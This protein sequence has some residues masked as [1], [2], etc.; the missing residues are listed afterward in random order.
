MISR[1][2]L[3][4]WVGFT[5]GIAVQAK[6]WPVF[7]GNPQ[8]TGTTTAHL[9]DQLTER[10]TFTCKNG[11]EGAPAIVGDTV[12]LASLGEH[13]YALELA[14]GR[15]K[16]RIRLAPMKAAPAVANGRVF[17]GDIDGKFYCVDA[18]TGKKLWMFETGGEITSGA[19]FHGDRV[20]VGSHDSTLYCL[21]QADGHKLWSYAIDG[22]VNGS[23]AISGNVAIVAGCD[24][25]L[26]AVD[27]QTGQ[28]TGTVELSGQAGATAAVLDG[29]AYVGTMSNQVVSVRIDK[30]AKLWQFEARRRQQPFYAS[31]AVTEELVIAGSRDKK[32]YALDRK[33]GQEKWNFLTGGQVDA[34]PVVV[35]NRV[36]VGALS[37]DGEFY[38]LDL[39]TGRQI[40][41]LLLD[42]AISGSVA[43][44]GEYLLVGTEK[45]TLYC[46]GAALSSK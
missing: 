23:P 27:I 7:R 37:R 41:Q 11:L 25:I 29:Q 5:S 44:A 17:V 32:I 2:V 9:P 19:N 3:S 33:T 21:N 43:V 12:Y 28:A 42:S 26:H 40:Q 38:V 22:P 31:A 16:W 14:T 45:G 46:F 10:W 6:D 8:M 13:L 35:G 4:C 15:E 1:F 34:S 39:K 24:S 36:Y 18:K 30:P 20:L